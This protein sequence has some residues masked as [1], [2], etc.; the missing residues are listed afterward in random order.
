MT[1]LKSLAIVTGLLLAG[2]TSIA[3]AQNGPAT[4]GEP[5]VAGGA[6]GNAA[7]PGSNYLRSATPSQYAPG[8][9]YNYYQ[10]QGPAAGNAAWCE[11]HYRSYDPT[12]GMYRGFDGRMRPCR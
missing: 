11:S 7:A 9:Y 10:G 12:T 1:T 2:G 4:G 8:Q 6:A 5:A 3:M